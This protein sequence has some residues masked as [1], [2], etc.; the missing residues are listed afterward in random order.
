MAIIIKD[1]DEGL[2]WKDG[3][4]DKNW[5]HK[6]WRAEMLA[7]IAVRA[8][9]MPIDLEAL[10]SKGMSLTG[11]SII[12]PS[13]IDGSLKNLHYAKPVSLSRNEKKFSGGLTNSVVS[14]NAS[15]E[16][17]LD[18]KTDGT[19]RIMIRRMFANGTQVQD[20]GQ[21]DQYL[22]IDTVA[23]GSGLRRINNPENG[24]QPYQGEIRNYAKESRYI[25]NNTF[26]NIDLSNQII[27]WTVNG[28]PIKY[29]ML[30]NR[31]DSIQVK[32]NATWVAVKS[33]GRNLPFMMYTG[34][35]DVISFE[36]SWYN[37][38]RDYKDVITR[39]RAIESLTRANGYNNSPPVLRIQWGQSKIFDNYLWV[40][41]SC[42][43][44][45]SNFQNA[46]WK[47]NKSVVDGSSTM[48]TKDDITDC[49]LL[50]AVATQTL[51]FK[52]VSTDNPNWE[53]IIGDFYGRYDSRIRWND[54][55]EQAAV[56]QSSED[57]VTV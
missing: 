6:A 12:S 30:Q 16:T 32:P 55:T 24:D 14:T 51:T 11:L 37:N 18:T 57:W 26:Q 34:G 15:G 17:R 56:K 3:A 43:Y 29:I 52:K 45:L 1:Y 53:N 46:A 54:E 22:D 13:F 44:T 38:N 50:P 31:P 39:C 25:M 9:F 8:I 19:N 5:M 21:P 47:M 33:M 35:E 23:A 41:E 40:L 2:R 10:A 4:Y 42:P 48:G 36:V 28:N 49:K 20:I 27:I 7:N